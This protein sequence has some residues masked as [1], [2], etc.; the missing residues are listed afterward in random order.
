M[1]ANLE[2]PQ[3]R[4]CYEGR[5]WSEFIVEIDGSISGIK[6]VRSVGEPLDEQV[7]RVLKL[8]P[9]FIPAKQN[10]QPVRFRYRLPISFTLR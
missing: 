10:G 7:I 3:G 6:I 1:N 2:Y 8:L 5:V 4:G 9:I